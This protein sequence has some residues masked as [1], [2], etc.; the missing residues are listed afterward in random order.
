M[1][2]QE[3]IVMTIVSCV[4]KVPELIDEYEPDCV[5]SIAAKVEVP[6]GIEHV[7]FNF[8]DID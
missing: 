5:L 6:K 1:S 8:A 2:I 3:H 4:A 7:F